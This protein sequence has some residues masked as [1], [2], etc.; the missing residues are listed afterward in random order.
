M[1]GVELANRE[2]QTS[3]RD[4]LMS[5]KQRGL[6][7]VEF[8]VTDDHTGLKKAGAEIL[9]QAVWQRCY[10]HFLRNAWTI[11]PARPTTTACRSCAGYMTAATSGR[12][13]RISPIGCPGSVEPVPKLCDSGTSSA[14]TS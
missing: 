7:G 6:S 5:L 12:R 11:C 9:P 1:L 3:W 14:E 8:V 13:S 4:F 2:S 10:V